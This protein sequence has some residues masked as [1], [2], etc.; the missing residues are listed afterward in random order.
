M[1]KTG[2]IELA[3]KW[4][5]DIFESNY[6]K[7]TKDG[8]HGLHSKVGLHMLRLEQFKGR[9]WIQWQ[10][11]SELLCLHEVWID[12]NLLDNAVCIQL[13]CKCRAKVAAF[14][15][16]IAIRIYYCCLQI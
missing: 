7:V 12:D 13:P 4:S 10:A 11:S 16:I 8:P 9:R 6:G 5:S 3:P 15:L 1:L 2:N 14:H